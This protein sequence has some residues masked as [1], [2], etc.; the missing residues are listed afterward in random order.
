MGQYLSVGICTELSIDKEVL[1]KSTI[2]KIENK[3]SKK[4][5]MSLF[6][7]NETEFDD[8]IVWHLKR[9]LIKEEMYNFTSKIH[10]D[11]GIKNEEILEKI[12][13][14]KTGEEIYSI[15]GNDDDENFRTDRYSESEYIDLGGYRPTDIQTKYIS[16]LME[17]KIIMECYNTIFSFFCKA[18]K[19][20]YSE[21]KLS[22]ALNVY[23]TG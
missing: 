6:V 7:I 9:D 3:L 21:F 4:F 23:I 14:A 15:A 16:F 5:D 17:G 10:A 1:K 19:K 11:Y 12:K 8:V 13:A 22:G 18:L 20:V 2:E